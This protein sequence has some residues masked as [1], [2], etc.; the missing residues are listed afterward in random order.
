MSSKENKDIPGFVKAFLKEGKNKYYVRIDNSFIED[1]FNYYGLENQVHGY[2]EAREYLLD[3]KKKSITQEDEFLYNGASILYGLIHARFIVIEEGLKK[4]KKKYKKQE[5]GICPRY[6]C[7]KAALLPF[8]PSDKLN[9]SNI[10]LCMKTMSGKSTVKKNEKIS[11]RI[12]LFNGVSEIECHVKD[13]ELFI[14]QFK[15]QIRIKAIIDCEEDWTKIKI[16]E[17]ECIDVSSLDIRS[18][19]IKSITYL[20]HLFKTVN[21]ISSI[22]LPHTLLLGLLHK[23]PIINSYFEEWDCL[24]KIKLTNEVSSSQVSTLLGL[25]QNL[26]KSSNIIF[27]LSNTTNN[28]IQLLL[29]HINKSHIKLVTYSLFCINEIINK[30][31]LFLYNSSYSSNYFTPLQITKKQI[32]ILNSLYLPIIRYKTI[33]TNQV[34]N[35]ITYLS[36][37]GILPRFLQVISHILYFEYICNTSNSIQKVDLSSLVL[38]QSLKII[39]INGI[40]HQT[41]FVLPKNLLYLSFTNC[42]YSSS[43]LI[44]F[45]NLQ[46]LR[47]L[48]LIE[49]KLRSVSLPRQIK[50]LFCLNNQYPILITNKKSLKYF[51]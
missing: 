22:S 41:S 28:I 37:N 18:I 33:I 47:S 46:S 8:S 38:L 51:N 50:Y 36:I 9:E 5:F 16:L 40:I 29:K 7:N 42:L 14:N 3:K 23:D 17:N 11:K 1:S 35:Q 20:L 48:T 6:Y 39:N 19:H 26:N 32:N 13:I 25:I 43:Q 15:T 2:K 4:M 21:S 49:N 10:Q 24:W 30:Q 31:I 45:S 44:N 34:T 12:K 27:Y